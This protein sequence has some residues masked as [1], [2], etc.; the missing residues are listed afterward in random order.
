MSMEKDERP[1]SNVTVGLVDADAHR[2]A[3]LHVRGEVVADGEACAHVVVELALRDGA[4]ARD[5]ALGSVATDAK[6]AYEGALVVPGNVPLGDYE[7][8]A[9]TPGDARCGR[10]A[11]PSGSS[12]PA[13]PSSPTRGA[14]TDAGVRNSR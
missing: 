8:V 1:L 2:G 11:T 9:R 5:V 3:P 7:I 12:S 14:Q 6:G 4:N 13:A 10:S